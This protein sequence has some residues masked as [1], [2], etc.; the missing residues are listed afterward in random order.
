MLFLSK[1][2]IFVICNMSSLRIASDIKGDTLQTGSPA[3]VSAL[4]AYATNTAALAGGLLPGALYRVTVG[5]GVSSP[6]AVVY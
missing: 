2:K 4:P 5:A 1:N 6:V 3:T